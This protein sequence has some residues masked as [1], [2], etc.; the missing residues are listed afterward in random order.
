MST[1][2]GLQHLCFPWTPATKQFAYKMTGCLRPRLSSDVQNRAFAK[3]ES[4]TQILDAALV[5]SKK[6]EFD[7]HWSFLKI[8]LDFSS[9][10]DEK[11]FHQFFGFFF[12]VPN[13]LIMPAYN[14]YITLQHF[15]QL[16]FTLNWLFSNCVKLYWS[17]QGST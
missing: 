9:P 11:C 2:D 13:K 7:W 1:L 16:Q 12:L 17:Y 6:T 5:M 4:C 8:S 15:F 3:N 10:S 14:R